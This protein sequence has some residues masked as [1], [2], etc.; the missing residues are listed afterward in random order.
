MAIELI[1]GGEA[2]QILNNGGSV[3]DATK[4]LAVDAAMTYAGVKFCKVGGKVITQA[5]GEG[6]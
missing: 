6:F 3:W 5:G 1:P 4:S 2:Y